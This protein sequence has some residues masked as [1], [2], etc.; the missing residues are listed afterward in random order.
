[1]AKRLAKSKARIDGVTGSADG[2]RPDA[3][4]SLLDTAGSER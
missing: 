3:P 1:V 2:D 4:G